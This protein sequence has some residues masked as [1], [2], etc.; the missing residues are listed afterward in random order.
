M[1]ELALLAEK[2]LNYTPNNDL[3]G[4]VTGGIIGN[5]ADALRGIVSQKFWKSS[6]QWYQKK[7]ADLDAPVNATLQR[8]IRRSYLKSL[9]QTCDQSIAFIQNYERDEAYLTSQRTKLQALYHK[10]QRA[11]PSLSSFPL[12][13]AGY[14][15]RLIEIIRTHLLTEIERVATQENLPD[16][17]ADGLFDELVLWDNAH[18]LSE[19]QLLLQDEVHSFVLHELKTVREL[20]VPDALETLLRL[21]WMHEGEKQTFFELMCRNFEEEI[22]KVAGVSEIFNAKLLAMLGEQVGEVLLEVKTNQTGIRRIED[23]LATFSEEV[24]NDI[25]DKLATLDFD[26]YKKHRQLNTQL[27]ELDGEFIEL[28]PRKQKVE[29]KIE[30]TEDDETRELLTDTLQGLNSNLLNIDQQRSV[31]RRELVVFEDDVRTLALS[32]Y[33]ERTADSPRLQM[34]T[35]LFE[36]G[37]LE[38]ANRVLNP[39]ELKRDKQLIEKAEDFLGQRRQ[40]LAQEYLTKAKLVVLEKNTPNWFDEA[41]YFYTEAVNLHE[42]YDNCFEAADFLHNNN[43]HSAAVSYYERGLKHVMADHQKATVLNNLANLHSDTQQ[44]EKAEEEYTEALIICRRLVT[45]NPEVYLPKIAAI[46]NNL[47]NLHRRIAKRLSQAEKEYAEALETYRKLVAVNPE[48]YLPL[49]AATLNNLAL[50]HSDTQKFS[51]AEKRYAEALGIRRKLAMVDP[52][53]YQPDVAMTLNNLGILHRTMQHYLQAEE[54]HIEAL[55]I[56]RKLAMIN[57][58]AYLPDVAVTLNSLAILHSDMQRAGQAEEEFAEA[59]DIRRE[60]AKHNPLAFKLDFATTLVNVGF[61]YQKG[62]IIDKKRSL[63]YTL[64]AYRNAEAYAYR[65]EIS[66]AQKICQTAIQVWHDWG[67]DLQKHIQDR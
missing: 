3:A 18:T 31:L 43:Q 35:T 38:G 27:S 62:G 30:T 25:R 19:R 9:V 42:D 39:E 33:S 12:S 58:E 4:I 61:F 2:L 37:D 7:I 60:L 29:H 51:R 17:P 23:Q 65:L 44:T 55:D 64:Q 16:N 41:K 13:D 10:L 21:G 1:N 5:R 66:L 54:E 56:R 67:E 48:T 26:I 24:S 36:Q 53:A 32:L 22:A 46:L 14:Q 63:D 52:E 50:L 28:S 49:V 15:I 57:P 20:D 59:L 40:T 6:K 8:A 47:A 11:L 34:A 45:V